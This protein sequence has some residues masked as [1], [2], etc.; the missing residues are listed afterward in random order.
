MTLSSSFFFFFFFGKLK[1][2][3]KTFFFFF[4]LS[5]F[6]FLFF[7]QIKT[8]RKNVTVYSHKNRDHLFN[9][10]HSL[11]IFNRCLVLMSCIY[12]TMIYIFSYIVLRVQDRKRLNML[13]NSCR[14]CC[15]CCINCRK[16]NALSAP[17]CNHS[18][19]NSKVS[20]DFPSL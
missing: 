13:K 20:E 2:R 3:V 9:F 10:L 5:F 15:I 8:A 17:V 6:F 7:W 11:E 4:F 14:L 16:S 1:R 12:S 18:N 19:Y